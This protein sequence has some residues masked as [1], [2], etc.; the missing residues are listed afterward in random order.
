M[1]IDKSRELMDQ[2]SPTKLK[3]ILKALCK[4]VENAA[5][6]AIVFATA[7]E[8]KRMLELRLKG[9]SDLVGNLHKNGLVIENLPWSW[10]GIFLAKG[11]VKISPDLDVD[12]VCDNLVLLDPPWTANGNTAQYARAR[13]TGP[14][15][16]ALISCIRGDSGIPTDSLAPKL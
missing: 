2:S 12:S 5:V 4:D 9:R 11:L 3:G 13:Y 7:T 14:L 10:N 6:V 15:T 8:A 16:P 1:L